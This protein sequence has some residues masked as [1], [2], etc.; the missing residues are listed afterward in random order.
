MT[1]RMRAVVLATAILALLLA[2]A[3][4]CQAR[5]VSFV[6]KQV[7]AGGLL[8][9]NY[10]NTYGMQHGLVFPDKAMVKKGGG[11]EDADPHLA[12][13]SVDRQA[14]GSRAHRA[15]RT[16]TRSATAAPPTR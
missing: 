5:A 12:V 8:I 9:Q 15:A 11:L 2:A 14:D 1:R 10:I 13:E 6:D 7:Q 3:A 4:P 16:R